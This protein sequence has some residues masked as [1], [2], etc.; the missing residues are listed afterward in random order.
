MLQ[1][2]VNAGENI[3]A[4]TLQK[5]WEKTENLENTFM[6]GRHVHYP[7][8]VSQLIILEKS[9][10]LEFRTRVFSAGEDAIIKALSREPADAF[11]WAR[12]CWFEILQN[13]PGENSLNALK[14]SVYTAPAKRSLIFWR[15]EMLALHIN[16]WNTEIESLVRR[17]I[18]YAWKISPRRTASWAA[19]SELT[20]MLRDVLS[21][22]DQQRLD[23]IL[24]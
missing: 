6:P 10:P 17:Q 24:D 14:M 23:N 2:Q 11:A 12:L 8:L 7:G 16:D 5:V 1:R 19:S 4:T 20:E 22:K 3:S 21:L 9:L 15:L 13:G 18:E